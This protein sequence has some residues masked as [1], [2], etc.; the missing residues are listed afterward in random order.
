L[1]GDKP[2]GAAL[3]RNLGSATAPGEAVE[4]EI[5][6]FIQRRDWQRRQTEGERAIEAAWRE[7]ERREENRTGWLVWYR[8]LER[9][10]LERA[11]ECC[12][13]ARALE[14]MDISE[15]ILT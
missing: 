2:I 7:S 14:D 3:S 6:Q 10:H 1:I 9:V 11:A 12:Q 13:R 15:R 4:A 5:D 8:R